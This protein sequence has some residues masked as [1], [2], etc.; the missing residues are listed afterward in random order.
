MDHKSGEVQRFGMTWDYDKVEAELES[1]WR[2]WVH[3]LKARKVLGAT[4]T[5]AAKVM[6][7]GSRLNVATGQ[8]PV[9]AAKT[10]WDR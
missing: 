8:S 3:S 5:V 9:I 10:Y 1:T 4:D 7:V 2:V 6:D